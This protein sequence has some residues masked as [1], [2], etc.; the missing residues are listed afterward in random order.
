[1]IILDTNVLS[2]LM[3]R[4]PDQRVLTWFALVPVESVWTTTITIFEI[5]NGLEV[6]VEGRRRRELTDALEDVL[7]HDLNDRFVSFDRSAAE[8]AATIAGSQRRSGRPAEIRDVQIAGIVAARKA[9][10]ATRNTRHFESIGLPLVNPW[11]G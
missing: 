10:L 6:L 7:R 8:A 11:S 1:M 4:E 3:Q 9:T 5:R 2:A